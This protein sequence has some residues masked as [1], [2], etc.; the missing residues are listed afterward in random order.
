[1]R[2][3]SVRL[4]NAETFHLDGET[5]ILSLVS[6]MSCGIGAQPMVG[7]VLVGLPDGAPSKH[8]QP[9]GIRPIQL[10]VHVAVGCSPRRYLR[11]RRAAQLRMP[12]TMGPVISMMSAL[13]IQERPPQAF[14]VVELQTLVPKLLE[15]QE[16]HPSAL[17]ALHPSPLP[18]PQVLT[19]SP[20]PALLPTLDPVPRLAARLAIP[21]SLDLHLAAIPVLHDPVPRLAALPLL[22]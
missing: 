18:L 21:P 4:S 6:T 13:W 12:T 16:A 17:P 11:H 1:M 10:A 22:A 14:V 5:P 15:A 7:M 20:L 2:T 3:A 19:P 8:M 9:E